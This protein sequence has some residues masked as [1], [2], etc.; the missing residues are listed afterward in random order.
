MSKE[1]QL[2]ATPRL[3]KR[4]LALACALMLSIS[5]FTGCGGQQEN[6]VQSSQVVS[7]NAQAE[8]FAEGSGTVSDPWK[9]KTAEQLDL[10][11]E[12]LS[13]SYVLAADIDLSSIKSF[14][15]IGTFAPKSEKEEDAETP[16]E[17]A[18]F[19]GTFDG[20]GYKISNVTISGKYQN[21]VGLFG[22]ISGENAQLKNV[23]VENIVVPASQMYVGGI[24]GY[25]NGKELSGLNLQGNNC[26]TG[27]FLVGGIVGASHA[28]IKDCKA[29]GTVIL[30]G[31]NTQGAGLIVGGAEDCNVENCEATGT[32]E[33][34]GTGCYSIGGLAGCFHNSEY[35][36]NCTVDSVTIV[37]GEKSSLIGGLAGHAGTMNGEAT[38]ITNCKANNFTIQAAETANRIGGIVGGGFYLNA[39]SKYY[40]QPTMYDVIGCA[41]SGKIDGG[42]YVGTVAGYV[43]NN[44]VVKDCTAQVLINE[45]SNAEEI[46]ADYGTWKEIS[47]L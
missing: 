41:V 40:A 28:N 30:S 24:V 15:P 27:H 8:G 37:A 22:C 35:A 47:A 11:R 19:S 3:K 18:A 32:V 36:K 9:I 25:A 13:G 4:S 1:T 44:A 33:V 39:Y 2:R 16:S 26:V 10:V 45:K 31:D 38:Q 5:M 7:A 6:Q 12:K 43:H 17:A 29:S 23:T 14:D 20:A 46:G 21:G 34:K 42:K